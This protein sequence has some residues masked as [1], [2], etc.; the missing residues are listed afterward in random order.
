MVQE[1]HLK[2]FPD[3]QIF[4]A[5]FCVVLGGGGLLEQFETVY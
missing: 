4:P 2:A 5:L 1:K 3:P